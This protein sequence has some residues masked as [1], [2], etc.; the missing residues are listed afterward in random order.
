MQGYAF[1]VTIT[2]KNPTGTEQIV[3]IP[4]GTIIE[5]QSSHL[6]YQSAVISK[7]YIFRLNPKETRS[8]MLDAECWNQHLSPPRNIS[9]KL[10]P[11]K[12]NIEETT[13]IWG[14]SS[15]PNKYIQAKPSQD[16]HIFP[17]FA[18][19][20][21]ELAYEFLQ[22]AIQRAESDGIDVSLISKELGTISKSSFSYSKNQDKLWKI[23]QS[24][25]QLKQLCLCI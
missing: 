13:N 4:R 16:S 10:T 7:D 9:G 19:T 2:L 22:Q 25:Y 1:P 15:S 21:P 24:I 18:N 14:K 3:N 17:A 23:A 8:V 6:T 11:L 20:I 12:G 5:P